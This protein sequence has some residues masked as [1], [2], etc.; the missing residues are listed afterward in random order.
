M[1]DRLIEAFWRPA[2]EVFAGLAWFL[3]S[4]TTALYGYYDNFGLRFLLLASIPMACIGILRLWQ[5]NK[6]LSLKSRLFSLPDI[7]MNLYDVIMVAKQ[8]PEMIYYGHGFKWEQDS[9]QKA[10]DFNARKAGDMKPHKLY[11][12]LRHLLGSTGNKFI[13]GSMYLHSMGAKEKPVFK[14]VADRYTHRSVGG[15]T[16]TGK[17]RVMAIDII[18]AIVRNNACLMIDP[19]QDKMCVDTAYATMKF[20]NKEDL[21]FFF[22]PEEPLSS[23]RIN[24]LANFSEVSQLTDRICSLMDDNTDAFYKNYTWRGL[25]VILSGLVLLDGQ[26]TL[27]SLKRTIESD[28]LQF[29]H[30][31]GCHYLKQFKSTSKVSAELALE[32]DYKK[33]V[34]KLIGL[35]ETHL[36]KDFSHEAIEGLINLIRQDHSKFKELMQNIM[37]ILEML[38]QGDLKELLSP[39]E[40]DSDP[41]PIVN[42]KKVSDSHGFL[43]VNLASLTDGTVGSKIGELIVGDAVSV[44]GRR[45]SSPLASQAPF[46]FWIDEAAEV[47][48]E[49]AVV[50]ANKTRSADLAMT[51]AFQTMGDLE[52]RLGGKAPA[53][54]LMGNM[55]TKSQLR[56]GC[57]FTSEFMSSDMGTTKI[58]NIDHGHTTQSKAM[59]DDLDFNTSYNKSITE[60]EV[61]KVSTS[62]LNALAD[63]HYFCNFPGSEIYKL[64]VP[65][66]PI[67]KHLQYPRAKFTNDPHGK[68]DTIDVMSGAPAGKINFVEGEPA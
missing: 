55:N 11:Q 7:K 62:S 45:H 35:Y 61:P 44:A 39:E 46:F 47:V 48:N 1:K 31:V 22:N 9:T 49:K 53:Q 67:P 18:Q 68:R 3:A 27:Y 52:N 66:I 29:F 20:M 60:T 30:K 41:R 38:T 8:N 12:W 13:K 2:Y 59:R 54:M 28:L 4:I 5:G 36:K 25:Q 14:P 26:P 32:T 37:P 57:S 63:L 34:I 51:L 23:V 56:P 50:V 17:G 6:I 58:K 42:L 43:Y 64:R 19:K 10:N 21:F 40:G 15:T 65:Y 16:G 33:S 24:P